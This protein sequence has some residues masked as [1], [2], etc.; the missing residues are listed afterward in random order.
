ME[1]VARL[2]PSRALKM[3]A[4]VSRPHPFSL[5]WQLSSRRPFVD[6][7]SRRGG[8]ARVRPDASGRFCCRRSRVRPC[9][10]GRRRRARAGGPSRES[11]RDARRRSPPRGQQT[12]K[13][14][15]ELAGGRGRGDLRPL[16]RPDPLEERPQRSRCLG[17]R[18]GGLAEHPARQAGAG[19]AD[20]AVAGLGVAGLPPP[21]V[22]AEL[23]DQLPRRGEAA[24][25]AD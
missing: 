6:R 25:V 8:R 24:D 12:P 22:E 19:F 3:R 20:P 21:R 5:G 13:Q 4:P 7:R 15:G 10:V 1:S 14:A 2:C 9:V 16:A 18:P 17:D 23:A 11:S